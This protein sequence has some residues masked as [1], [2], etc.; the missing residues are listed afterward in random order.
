VSALA[1]PRAEV[2]ISISDSHSLELKRIGT[3]S[4]I[5]VVLTLVGQVTGLIRETT[6]AYFLGATGRADAYIAAF[7]PIDIVTS[8]LILAV[9]FGLIPFL[10]NYRRR[11]GEAGSHW[12]IDRVQLGT[13]CCFLVISLFLYRRSEW[14]VHL[15]NPQLSGAQLEQ[16]IQLWHWMLPAIPMVSLTAF[17]I[18]QLIAEDRFFFPGANSIFLNLSI[19]IV[20]VFAWKFLG[21]K[22]FALGVLLGSFLQLVTQGWAVLGRHR[23]R[24]SKIEGTKP[25]LWRDAAIIIVPVVLLYTLGG[26]NTLI[27]RR[28]ASD[29]GEG[30][31]AVFT[32]ATRASLPIYLLGVYAISYPYFSTF[33]RAV[34]S[35]E[36]EQARR[37]LRSM[38]RSAVLFAL[39]A[40]SA[41][42]VLREP[43]VRI[44]FF[45]GA[46]DAQA[47]ESVSTTLAFLVPFVLGALLTDL[48]GRCLIAMGRTLAACGLYGVLLGLSWVLISGLHGFG[49]LNGVS[50]AWAFSLLAVAA[51]FLVAVNYYLRGQAFRGIG[52]S[53][54]RALVSG[55]AAATIMAFSSYCL[56][57]WL[58][59]GMT[60]S[61][62]NVVLTILAGS[63]VL[64][65]LARRLGVS[66]AMALVDAT[67]TVGR[68]LRIWLWG[69]PTVPFVPGV[70]QD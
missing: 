66:E 63:V 28:F 32:Y 29:L 7:Q 34:A 50:A 27:P 70:D 8:A 4:L 65:S 61:M 10:V 48:L 31:L 69:R 42:I 9:P 59:I 40:M 60:G 1:T 25:S 19:V 14:I 56:R 45:R 41:I 36:I 52:E 2:P 57:L 17:F 12:A 43:L 11:F 62:A 38:L 47:A 58:G 54:W 24:H 39:P 33:A 46:F 5:L 44:L 21:V 16:A 53:L 3:N 51:L 6:T 37:L 23:H 30:S 20:P 13:A 67:H 15:T 35:G 18:A 68:R 49:G 22:A 26:L 64:I 55:M